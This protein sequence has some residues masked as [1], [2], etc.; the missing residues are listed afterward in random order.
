MGNCLRFGCKG[1]ELSSVGGQSP[2][3]KTPHFVYKSKPLGTLEGLQSKNPFPEAQRIR[4]LTT[5]SLKEEVKPRKKPRRLNVALPTDTPCD[6]GVGTAWSCGLAGYKPT[7][8]G[9][10]VL[11][12][13][14]CRRFS[15][16]TTT[17]VFSSRG[18]SLLSPARPP[19]PSPARTRPLPKRREA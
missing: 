1:S 19:S 9:P 17:P 16:G 2:S 18:L 11:L 15:H 10:P 8:R 7:S 12:A 3:W 13:T 5:E 6:S 4:C 14:T